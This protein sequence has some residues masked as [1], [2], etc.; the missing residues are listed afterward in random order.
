VRIERGESKVSQVSKSRPGAPVGCAEDCE[1]QIPFGND[2]KKGKEQGQ[3][4]RLAGLGSWYL[5]SQNRDLGHR[6]V[7]LGDCEKQIPFGND[8]KKGKNKGKS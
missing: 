2:N 1:K 8:N 3:K 4:L 7:V 6:L 5:R